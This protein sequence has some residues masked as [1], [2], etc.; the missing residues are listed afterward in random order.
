VD[1]ISGELLKK[2]LTNTENNVIIN[3]TKM[4]ERKIT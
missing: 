2:E 1:K 3:S 4:K